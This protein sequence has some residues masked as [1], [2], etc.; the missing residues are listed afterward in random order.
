MKHQLAISP[1]T[2][3][4]NFMSNFHFFQRY[5]KGAGIFGV[6]G[7]LGDEAEIEF[8]R[9]HFKAS[10]FPIPTHRHTKRVELPALQV[11]GGRDAWIRAICNQVRERKSEK[12]WVKG[13]AVLVVCE[14]VRTADELQKKLLE[15][16]AVPSSD[17]ITMYTRSDEH[18]VEEKT[19]IPGDVVI[20]TNLGGRG[21]DFKI[22]KD[23]NES[24]GLCVILTHFP[25]NMRIEKQIFG[26]TSRK[27][28]PGMVQMVLNYENLAPSYQDQPI[29]IMRQLRANYEKTRIADMEDDELLEVSMRQELFNFFCHLL[30]EFD[31]NYAELEKLD[32]FTCS[33]RASRCSVFECFQSKMDFKPALNALKET[34]ALWLTLH[35]K[36]IDNHMNL[37]QLKNNLSQVIQ[38]RIQDVLEGKSN[39][40]YDFIKLAM[41]RM[42]LHT[43]EKKKEF[44]A[45]TY[46]EK[47]ETVDPMY[48]AVSLYNRAYITVNLGKDG[49]IQ[50]AID[51]LNDTK[52]A[53]DSYIS[54]QANM[55]VAGQLSCIAQ[56]EPH[57]KEETNFTKQMQCRMNLFKSWIDY[58]DKSTEK[59]SEL[60]KQK[61]NAITKDV[62]VFSL[63]DDHNHITVEELNSLY[64][65]GLSFV[66][67][68]EKKP[69]FCIDALIC[70]ILGAL[71]ILAGILVC[72]V[73]FGTATQFGM[74]LI[75]EGVSDMIEGVRGMIEGA[76][77]WAEWAVSKA[78]NIGM[79][80]VTAGFSVIKKAVTGTYRAIKGLV[81]GTKTFASVA[82]DIIKSGKAV[83]TSVKST[84]TSAV[85]SV[86]KESLQQSIKTLATSSTARNS[87]I[88]AAKFAGK[89][90]VKQ[91][92]LT[93]LEEGLKAAFKAIFESSLRQTVSSAI[94]E[95]TTVKKYLTKFIIVHSVPVSVLKSEEMSKFQIKDE[96]KTPMKSLVVRMCQSA[97]ED[98]RNDFATVNTVMSHL[99]TV[100]PI[101]FTVMKEAKVPG[102]TLERLKFAAEF[103]K[104]TAEFVEMLNAIPT[105]DIIDRRVVPFIGSEIDA[106]LSVAEYKEDARADI[107]DVQNV[108]KDLLNTVC[109]ELSKEFIELFTRLLTGTVI[110]LEKRYL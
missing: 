65:M 24:G 6:S 13:Q 83:F 105:K 12:N 106:S 38:T 93:G 89:E 33:D 51:L 85:S 15:Y 98:V 75:S 71:Q 64:D 52:K 10:C 43:T 18:N 3:V 86:S 79:S 16:Q 21:T 36:D 81:T 37:D 35:E 80:L 104:Y 34:W 27:G 91:G 66:F 77:S 100:Q 17:K 74:G 20:A 4:T 47:A 5:I 54:E 29:E 58:I 45:L 84:V 61:E 103:A 9:K 49:Y 26:R 94:I 82:D 73:S 32:I 56:F 108:Q 102:S 68:V 53:I 41:D 39:N 67:E 70:F 90:I 46:W 19:F 55:T 44:G 92:V 62:A 95:N 88:Q 2:N 101:V 107:P 72:A 59:L 8:L 23:V 87:F 42:Y 30:N 7:T 97:V 96:N 31:A 28:N 14:D 78:I 60:Q 1:L 99:Q 40:F 25:K 57:C 109:E 63:S 76:F 50:K 11:E 69:R 48:R 110:K 22:N